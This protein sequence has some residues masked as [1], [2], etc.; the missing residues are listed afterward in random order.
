MLEFIVAKIQQTAGTKSK[1]YYLCLIILFKLQIQSCRSTYLL[2]CSIT[3][4]NLRKR[5]H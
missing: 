1:V 5:F 3:F 2:A 4:D